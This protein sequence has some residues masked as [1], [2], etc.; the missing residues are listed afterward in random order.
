MM[1]GSQSGLEEF[2]VLEL[3]RNYIRDDQARPILDA[4]AAMGFNHFD[5]LIF[6]R[7][8]SLLVV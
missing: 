5:H 6:V 1:T 7:G 4:L 3:L 8:T 2:R